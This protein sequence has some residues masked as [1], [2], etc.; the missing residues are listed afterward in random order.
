MTS[1]ATWSS[2]NADELF[3]RAVQ[4]ETDHLDGKLFIDYLEPLAMHEL[5]EQL[6]ELRVGISQG[7]A[8]RRDPLGRGSRET[9][10][11]HAAAGHR[12]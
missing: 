4:H 5:G 11:Y 10:R 2:T 3:S 6:R 9:P 1:K 12:P 7:Q 8:T